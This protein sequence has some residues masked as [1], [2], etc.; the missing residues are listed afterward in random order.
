MCFCFCNLFCVYLKVLY[1][2]TEG[3]S[4][5]SDT[6]PLAA[7]FA[8]HRGETLPSWRKCKQFWTSVVCVNS[9]MAFL[10]TSLCACENIFDFDFHPINCLFVFV[11]LCSSRFYFS[12]THNSTQTIYKGISL[13]LKT[14]YVHE[15]VMPFSLVHVACNL[16]TVVHCYRPEDLLKKLCGSMLCF[17]ALSIA[18]LFH[19]FNY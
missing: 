15:K 16:P 18:C 5:H 1:N 13:H 14:N 2:A 4:R 10:D 12:P 9:K 17:F 6:G 3:S 19:G 8:L 11:S 7:G